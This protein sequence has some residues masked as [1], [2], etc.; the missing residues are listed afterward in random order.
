[1][2]KYLLPIS[3][4]LGLWLASNFA[5]AQ[6]APAATAAAPAAATATV[7]AAKPAD[8]AKAEA[9][10]TASDLATYI[11]DNDKFVGGLAQNIDDQNLRIVALEDAKIVGFIPV[12]LTSKPTVNDGDAA[13]DT[14]IPANVKNVISLHING[15]FA[16]FGSKTKGAYFSKDDGATAVTTDVAGA[17]L[18]WN[19]SVIDYNIAS[20]DQIVLIASI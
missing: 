5:M 12:V 7:E 1:M 2:K 20:D 19:H 6:A 8:A 4:G 17:K 3:L 15:E 9:D 10:T 18:Y 16:L 13:S 14:V 11:F